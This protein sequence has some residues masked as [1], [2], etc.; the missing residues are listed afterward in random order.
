MEYLGFIVRQPWKIYAV[1]IPPC[2]VCGSRKTATFQVTIFHM[3]KIDPIK[4]HFMC[5]RKRRNGYKFT[6]FT[7]I[8]VQLFT[9]YVYTK[10]IN[11]VYLARLM[12]ETLTGTSIKLPKH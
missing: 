7:L 8:P 5:T 3:F 6:R 10:R 12:G 1:L 11:S 4:F 2:A 9:T